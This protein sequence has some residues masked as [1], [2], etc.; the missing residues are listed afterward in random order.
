VLDRSWDEAIV[1]VCAA[2]RKM[3]V[4]VEYRADLTAEA[5]SG[6][7]TVIR[8]TVWTGAGVE[9]HDGTVAYHS[10]LEPDQLADLVAG[11][12]PPE[13]VSSVPRAS[14]L[15]PGMAIGAVSGTVV[16]ARRR[17]PQAHFSARWVESDQIVKVAVSDAVIDDRRRTRR[18]RLDGVVQRS[19]STAR[20]ASEQVIDTD[21][22]VSELIEETVGRLEARLGVVEPVSGPAT[23]VFAPSIAGILIH[24]L[25]G[26]AAEADRVQRGRS[27]LGRDLDRFPRSLTVIDDPRRARGAWRFDDEGTPARP[28]ALIQDGRPKEL[29]HTLS[30]ASR[31]GQEPTGHS[32][33]GSF[34][35]RLLPRMGCTFVANGH[36]A[37]LEILQ[38]V[39]RGIYVRRMES[40]NT[41]PSTGRALFRI[42]DADEI[43]EG[44]IG[45][46]LQPHLL[47]TR[48]PQALAA[49][50]AIGDDLAFDRCIGS[51]HREGQPLSTS[52]G[53]PTICIGLMTVRF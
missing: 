35:E 28:V 45:A 17:Y 44:R 53:A 38:R 30:T 47:E 39:Q 32:R 40:A 33:R 7:D 13:E 21:I 27:W 31:S 16:E 1:A 42:T 49:I 22:P 50:E 10:D 20:A 46:A 19:G 41:D 11:H 36:D 8:Q 52:V 5:A 3:S 15:D 25:V 37:P 51:C 14:V 26:H 48:A 2:A 24:E 12:P 9:R 34:R 29:L 43:T 18:I 6:E 23:V 4:F